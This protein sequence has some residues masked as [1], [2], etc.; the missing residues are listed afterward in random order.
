MS[1]DRI[2]TRELSLEAMELVCG[3]GVRPPASVGAKMPP[4]GTGP[5]RQPVDPQPSLGSDYSGDSAGSGDGS[6][7]Y[8][9]DGNYLRPF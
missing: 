7:G 8:M 1:N 6:G 3:A 5:H 2:E 4:G 9:G